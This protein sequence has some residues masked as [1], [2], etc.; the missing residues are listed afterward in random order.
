MPPSGQ[1]AAAGPSEAELEAARNI[2]I[3]LWTLYAIGVLVTVLRTYARLKLAGWKRFQ[4]DDYLVWV[5]VLLYSAQ[6]TLGYE[7]GNLAH[8]LANNG[9]TDAQRAALSPDDPEFGL[10]VLGSKIQVAGWSCYSTLMLALKFAMLSFYLRLTSGL[11]RYRVRVYAGFALVLAGYLA[12]IGAVFLG[13]MPFHQYWQINPDPGNFCQAA[14][15]KP[16]VWSSFAAN[17]STDIYLIMIPL[18][19][20][21]G[22]GLRLIEKIASSIVLGAGIFVLVC[23]TIKTVF[24][25]SDDANGAELAGEWGTREAFVA[26]VTTNLPMVFPLFRV[27]LKPLFSTVMR[28]SDN[29]LKTPE[30][31]RSIGGGGGDGSRGNARRGPHRSKG[32]NPLTNVSFGSSE[33]RIVNE[34]KLQDMKATASTAPESQPETSGIVVRTEFDLSEDRSSHYQE[35]NVAR[36]QENW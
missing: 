2:N 12:S 3:T 10:R 34:M 9:M 33:E 16:I 29:R 18:P 36:I 13:C 4:A 11:D 6:T 35:R 19:L 24:V 28:S 8:G 32:P 14:V 26:V 31:F 5:A 25:F 15:S 17:I 30:G 1:A 21:W 23:A 22:S 27:W 7:V 20:L